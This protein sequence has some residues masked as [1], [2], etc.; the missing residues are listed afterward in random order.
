MAF[1][2]TT[3]VNSTLT[4]IRSSLPWVTMPLC[5]CTSVAVTPWL[6]PSSY[7]P[8]GPHRAWCPATFSGYTGEVGGGIGADPALCDATPT[9]THYRSCAGARRRVRVS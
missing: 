7:W 3:Q 4:D 8:L 9:L 2:Q 5:Q 1:L 6:T